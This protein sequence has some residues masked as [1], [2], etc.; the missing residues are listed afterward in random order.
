[1]F[2]ERLEKEASKWQTS[3]F[4]F[5]IRI[6]ERKDREREMKKNETKKRVK[7]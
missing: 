3:A 1:M 5:W 6:E 7:R 2:F 4:Y